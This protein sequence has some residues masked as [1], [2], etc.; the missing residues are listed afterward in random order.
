[1]REGRVLSRNSPSTPSCMKRS[2]QRQM[3]VFDLPVRWMI[4]IVPSPSALKEA[5]SRPARRASEGHCGRERWL[6]AGGDPSCCESDGYPG[7]H[8]RRIARAQPGRNPPPGFKCQIRS[9]SIRLN[10]DVADL[11][12]APDRPRR[13]QFSRRCRSGL[14]A[15][16]GL[17]F[18]RTY[19]KGSS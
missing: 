17:T 15:R 12:S 9:T 8:P 5:L 3:Q 7:A 14:P 4:S 2:C 1:M 18:L 16:R 19:S 6:P 11:R 10:G 13:H